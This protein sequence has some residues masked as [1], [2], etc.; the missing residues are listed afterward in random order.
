MQQES[1]TQTLNLLRSKRSNR[2]IIP[3]IYSP[4]LYENKPRKKI[5]RTIITKDLITSIKPKIFEKE[6]C[7]LCFSEIPS[8]LDIGKKN[9]NK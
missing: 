4:E 3:K 2:Q 5:K 8:I 9:I 7:Q 1:I 6:I